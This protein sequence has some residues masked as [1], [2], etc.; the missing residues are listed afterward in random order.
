MDIA[1]HARTM[2][3]CDHAAIAAAYCPAEHRFY[4][5]VLKSWVLLDNDT[6]HGRIVIDDLIG[7]IAE[8]DCTGS[9]A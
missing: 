5:A 8:P 2:R 1:S 3:A 6:Y 7:Q 9:H 4:R